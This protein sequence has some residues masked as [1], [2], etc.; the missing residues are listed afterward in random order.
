MR[1]NHVKLYTVDLFSF[2]FLL[3]VANVYTVFKLIILGV[4]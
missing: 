2:L 4:L 3:K 1:L